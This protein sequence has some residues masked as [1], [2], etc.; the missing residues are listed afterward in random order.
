MFCAC[1]VFSPAFFL[2]STK[3]SIVV[4]W[5]LEVTKGHLTPSGFPCVCA[6]ATGSC[7]TPVVTE[8][9]VTL[10]EVSLGCS[11]SFAPILNNMRPMTIGNCSFPAILFSLGAPSFI[12]ACDWLYIEATL[13]FFFSSFI[14]FFS[15][16]MFNK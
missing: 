7:A 5:L 10:S 16:N 12:Q 3:C 15:Y 1:L 2:S 9:H 4:P 6:C 11:G 8:G 13:T 14:S